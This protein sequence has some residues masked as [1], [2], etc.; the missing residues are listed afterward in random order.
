[1]PEKIISSAFCPRK[2][3]TLDS[4][5]TQR[6][7]SVILLLPLPLGPTIPVMPGEKD[8][9]VLSAKDLNPFISSRNNCMTA[10]FLCIQ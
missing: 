1:M 2:W 8:T 10:S 3:R 4:P 6:I 7:A 5:K 9:T